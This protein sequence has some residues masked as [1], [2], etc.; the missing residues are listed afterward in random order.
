MDKIIHKIIEQTKKDQ[1][2]IAIAFFGSYA[3]G[4]PHRD[5]DVC[6]FL[7]PGEYEPEFLS[8]K[9]LEYTP[10]NQKYDVQIFQQLPLYIQKRIL[11]EAKIVD[12]KNE[13]LLYD[14]YFLTLR[15]YEH[16][17]PI[18]EGYLEAVESG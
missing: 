15:D 12:C 6:L 13:D 7:K 16:Y 8:F 10:E 17:E 5:I 9:K 2:V 14:L 18:Y 3:R 4:E 1:A 11:K